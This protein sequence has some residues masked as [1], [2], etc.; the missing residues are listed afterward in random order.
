MTNRKIDTRGVIAPIWWLALGYFLFYIPYSALVKALS[1][2]LLEQAGVISS[3]IEHVASLEFLPAVL[4]GTVITMPLILFCLGWFKYLKTVTV[5]GIKLPHFSPM[6]ALSGVAFAIIIATT[7]L[8][9]TFH[10]VSILFALLLMRG[11]VL[12]MSPVLDKVF[13]RP[14]KWYSWL[15]F[16]SSIIAL[17]I[18]MIQVSEFVLTGLVFLNLCGYLLGYAFRLQA[19]TQCAKDV[20][21]SVNRRFFVEENISAMMTLLAVPGL[22]ALLG[23]GAPGEMLRT[24]FTTFFLSDLVWP[25]LL[26]GVLYGCLGVFGS[27]I[28]L[29]RRENTFAIPVNRCSSLLSGVVASAILFFAFGDNPISTVQLI[30]V[31]I[32]II[33][34]ILMSFFD[35][36]QLGAQGLRQK[37]VLF[38]CDHN[39]ARAP[40]AAAICNDYLEK[41]PKLDL[42]F[43]PANAVTSKSAGLHAPNTGGM[44][45]VAVSVLQSMGI[46]ADRHVPRQVTAS[47][48][49]QSDVVICM[50]GSQRDTLIGRHPWVE[51]KVENLGFTAAL[52]EEDASSTDSLKEIGVALRERIVDFFADRFRRNA[53]TAGE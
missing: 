36:Q 18:A 29:N 51:E 1:S 25:A 34:L 43:G 41:K 24:G 30:S 40:M 3:A 52:H 44:S 21:E 2:G 9:Y 31:A 38:I 28:Y 35:S 6:A 50:T 42:G 49:H 26:I 15:G 12:I 7:T 33:A 47:D 14:V 8:A 46:K 11:G 23:I 37:I 17:G 19:M 13:I 27:L 10:G 45:A 22:I 4:V 5:W 32:V 48:L 39:Q 20:S 16:G 53:Q